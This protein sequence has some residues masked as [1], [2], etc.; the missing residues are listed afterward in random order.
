MCLSYYDYLQ[1]MGKII[2]NK[3]GGFYTYIFLGS[4]PPSA[5][6]HTHN[7]LLPFI[8]FLS[9]LRRKVFPPASPPTHSR[10]SSHPPKSLYVRPI[11][12]HTNKSSDY[13]HTCTY[14]NLK[15]QETINKA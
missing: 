9:Y 5:N 11:L 10:P 8:L 6:L 15:S 4:P 7:N 13:I 14:N 2:I 3:E 12:I 1:Y